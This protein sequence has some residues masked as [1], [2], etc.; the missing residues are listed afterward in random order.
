M[1]LIPEQ[2]EREMDSQ[3]G[4][5][6]SIPTARKTLEKALTSQLARLSDGL[7]AWHLLNNRQLKASAWR[8]IYLSHLNR[9][10]PGVRSIHSIG[11]DEL[12]EFITSFAQDIAARKVKMISANQINDVEIRIYGAYVRLWEESL[13]NKQLAKLGSAY[14][15]VFIGA[16]STSLNSLITLLDADINLYPID[17]RFIFGQVGPMT[18]LPYAPLRDFGS[19][20]ALSHLLNPSA[21]GFNYDHKIVMRNS[22]L[23]MMGDGYEVGDNDHLARPTN[24]G[25]ALV[26]ESAHIFGSSGTS[27]INQC[28][29]RR[30][31]YTST[32]WLEDTKRDICRFAQIPRSVEE[33]SSTFAW[34]F[35][36]WLVK[37]DK[38]LPDTF[39]G[40][41]LKSHIERHSMKSVLDEM[42]KVGLI[43]I[44]SNGRIYCPIYEDGRRWQL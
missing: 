40:V 39:L 2:I 9:A 44:D 3:E 25:S 20:M 41:D 29:G 4:S 42:Q 6:F 5:P 21:A 35:E 13:I 26:H 15:L 19:E 27:W 10:N 11:D 8:L 31:P 28:S 32:F 34:N 23:S 30:Y 22:V 1:K 37:H 18:A 12:R 38:D 33:L 43:L 36:N 14:R 24:W 16:S 7:L 17:P